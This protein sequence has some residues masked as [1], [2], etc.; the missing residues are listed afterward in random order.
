MVPVNLS[1][2]KPVTEATQW[3]FITTTYNY[4]Q[5][6]VLVIVSYHHTQGLVEGDDWT[7]LN[8]HPTVAPTNALVTFGSKD[9]VKHNL[10]EPIMIVLLKMCAL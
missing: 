2:I 9:L 10:I 6:S 3:S 4:F 5:F 1:D 8:L 7:P